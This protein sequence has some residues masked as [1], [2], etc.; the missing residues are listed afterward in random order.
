[1]ALT[2]QQRTALNADF[3]E[4]EIATRKGGG[5]KVL[6][7]ALG[8]QVIDN[9]NAILGAGSWGYTSDAT[10]EVCESR[11]G[12]KGPRWHVTYVCR[13]VLTLD[14]GMPI[15]DYG[16]GHGVD[17]DLG[18]SI[19][20]AIKEAATD[21][22][23]RCAKSLGRRLGL[24]LYDKAQEHVAATQAEPE[25]ALIPAI[26]PGVGR[27][28]IACIAEA[29]TREEYERTK[30]DIIAT[31]ATVPLDERAAVTAAVKAWKEGV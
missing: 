27:A 25:P 31:W 18:A 29:K 12:E 15:S 3:P 14:G 30:R 20:S 10:R 19:E 6:S 16:V 13:C 9:L 1:M 28:M 7:Y 23:K 21:A 5:G 26:S 2:E 24:A 22:L 17:V 11:P 8:W 4:D